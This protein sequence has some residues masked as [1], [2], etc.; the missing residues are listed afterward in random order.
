MEE[1]AAAISANLRLAAGTGAHSKGLRA[2]TMGRD[3]RRTRIAQY[4]QDR[5][6]A[7]RAVRR[8][9]TEP[10]SDAA[11]H[12]FGRPSGAPLPGQWPPPY[13]A[14][15]HAAPLRG[16]HLS[17]R[18]AYKAC[19]FAPCRAP[20]CAAGGLYPHGLGG[21]VV[22]GYCHVLGRC[23]CG[24]GRRAG[25]IRR[26]SGRRMRSGRGGSQRGREARSG[27]RGGEAAP[28][29]VRGGRREGQRWPP[30]CRC[31]CIR[32]SVKSLGERMG[33]GGRPF[34]ALP[35]SRPHP[36]MPR[37]R[38]ACGP[39]CNGI[40]RVRDNA[41]G[42]RRPGLPR[43]MRRHPPLTTS[44]SV[45]CDHVP[46]CGLAG[47]HAASPE[48][49]PHPGRRGGSCRGRYALLGTSLASMTGMRL[50]SS[51]A[52]ATARAC[53][54]EGPRRRSAWNLSHTSGW[55][56]RMGGNTMRGGP[57]PVSYTLPLPVLADPSRIA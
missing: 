20:A 17:G 8:G 3:I 4:H 7:F 6:C 41:F 16:D 34:A 36:A 48:S 12:M 38:R 22:D 30:F 25:G 18:R 56:G 32:G 33:S 52:R 49:G 45:T 55:S 14:P 13:G 39:G 46:S 42:P 31:E 11:G 15:L 43:S 9:P 37:D 53:L 10:R 50:A 28:R 23:A 1:G 57:R 21:R 5:A 24:G 27:R 2:H 19:D 35:P 54:G 29:R 40:P 51:K 26:L 47:P 44:A